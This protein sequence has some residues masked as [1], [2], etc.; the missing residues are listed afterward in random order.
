MSDMLWPCLHTGLDNVA[1]DDDKFLAEGGS[2][3][4]LMSATDKLEV[5]AQFSKGD[6]PVIFRFDAFGHS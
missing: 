6:N 1:V 4:A 5:A 2:E 3:L